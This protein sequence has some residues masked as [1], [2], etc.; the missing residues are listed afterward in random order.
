M[1]TFPLVPDYVFKEDLGVPVLVSTFE[2]GV[3]QRRR[4][5]SSTRRSFKLNFKNISQVDYETLMAFFVARNG[6]YENF[7]FYN[8]NDEQTYTCRFQDN[9]ISV[10]RVAFNRYDCTVTLIEVL[11]EV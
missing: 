8:E 7:D 11:G 1:A 4:K 6:P 3:E 2:I 9:N 5:A 10:D